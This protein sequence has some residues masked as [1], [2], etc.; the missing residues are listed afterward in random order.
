MEWCA[1][2]VMI[3]LIAYVVILLIAGRNFRIILGLKCDKTSNRLC[4]MGKMRD[5]QN[6]YAI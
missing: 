5:D 3:L 1:H 4:Q 2:D 6:D